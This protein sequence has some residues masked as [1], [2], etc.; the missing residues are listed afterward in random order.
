MVRT[1]LP[2][3]SIRIPVYYMR[4]DNGRIIIDADGM[5]QELDEWLCFLE[6]KG[7][8]I[9]YIEGEEEDDE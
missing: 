9:D 8:A 1:K 4:N 2:P 3:K 7:Y 6:H 5:Q